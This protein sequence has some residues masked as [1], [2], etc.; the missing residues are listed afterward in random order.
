M[1]IYI[2]LYQWIISL[3]LSDLQSFTHSGSLAIKHSS[4]PALFIFYISVAL[5]EAIHDAFHA[6]SKTWTMDSASSSF[7]NMIVTIF[8]ISDT[9]LIVIHSLYLLKFNVN[10]VIFQQL[11]AHGLFACVVNRCMSCSSFAVF[12]P[13]VVNKHVILNWSLGPLLKPNYQQ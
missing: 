3:S 4:T 6:A 2:S 1:A 5:I 10:S 9:I 7:K 8:I 12:R 11:S 13:P